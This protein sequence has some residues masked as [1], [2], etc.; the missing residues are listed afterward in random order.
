MQQSK[1]QTLRIPCNLCLKYLS[2]M[3][4]QLRDFSSTESKYSIYKGGKRKEIRPLIIPLYAVSFSAHSQLL[5][6]D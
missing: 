6:D 3:K 1:F 5:W 2:T 4:Y